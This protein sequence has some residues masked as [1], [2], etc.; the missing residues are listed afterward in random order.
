MPLHGVMACILCNLYNMQPC[1]ERQSA[2]KQRGAA[3][4]Y[5]CH[6]L[7]PGL[8]TSVSLAIAIVYR[9]YFC[10]IG[11]ANTFTKKVTE[12]ASAILFHHQSI[13]SILLCQNYQN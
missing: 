7:L 4:H 3:S 1:N 12:A 13:L 10:S 11:I 2:A 6:I 5:A 9:W 8:L